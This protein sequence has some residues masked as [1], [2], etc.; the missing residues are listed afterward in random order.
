MNKRNG[1][2][3]KAYKL[4]DPFIGNKK[5]LKQ[6]KRLYDLTDSYLLFKKHKKLKYLKV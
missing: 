2:I 1:M 3:S 6:I 5:V 4:C